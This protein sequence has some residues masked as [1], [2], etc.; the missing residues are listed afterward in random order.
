MHYQ[1]LFEKN[2]TDLSK[3]WEA[4]RSIINVGRKVKFNPCF[5]KH[6]GALFFNLIKKAETFNFFFTNIGL[7]I[8]KRIPK[9][10]KSLKTY[11]K[12]KIL[13]SFYFYP[14]TPDEIIKTIKCSLTTNHA[15]VIAYQ[16]LYWGIVLITA[17]NMS[18]YGI[19]SGQYFPI[20]R[21]QA[22]VI[23]IFKIY[24]ILSKSI[25]VVFLK[26][27]KS[28]FLLTMNMCFFFFDEKQMFCFALHFQNDAHS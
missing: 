20:F 22:V 23:D 15:V 13:K 26:F 25:F 10:K 2:K 17:W 28:Y 6:N 1:D 14:T 12:N 16:N 18:K 21:L 27:S 3:T 5:W 7:N 11:L 9:G 8:V 24:V 4:I 19:F